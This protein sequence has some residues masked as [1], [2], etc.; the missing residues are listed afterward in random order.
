MSEKGIGMLLG[1]GTGALFGLLVA[2]LILKY[3][4]TNGRIKC[5]YDERQAVLR[6]NGYRYGFFAM[7]ICNVV[8]GF[9]EICLVGLPLTA[10]VAMILSVLIGLGVQI[11]YCIWHDCYFSLNERRPRVLIALAVIG[12]INLALGI[13]NLL[14]GSAMENGVLN[15]RC[16]NLLCGLL[17]VAVFAALLMKHLGGDE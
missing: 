10:G 2:V 8:Y 13:Y 5:E 16:I 14:D 6:G 7:L 1:V 4:K 12:G 15:F 17:F 11:I 3:T 9:L